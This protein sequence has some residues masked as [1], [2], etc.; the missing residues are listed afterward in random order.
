[1][2]YS[3]TKVTIK[4]QEDASQ[5]TQ[6]GE[7]QTSAQLLSVCAYGFKYRMRLCSTCLIV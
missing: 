3:T 7:D 4:N 2:E 1:M 5:E 6:K